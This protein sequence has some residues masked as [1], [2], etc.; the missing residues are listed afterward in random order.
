MKMGRY[1]GPERSFVVDIREVG[2][3]IV[4]ARD[5]NHAKAQ[6]ARELIVARRASL[7]APPPDTPEAPVPEPPTP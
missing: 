1:I 4:K 3:V 5:G 6:I 2:E 7:A